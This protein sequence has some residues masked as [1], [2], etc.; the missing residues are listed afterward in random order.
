MTRVFRAVFGRLPALVLVTA[1]TL[2]PV[3]AA[4]QP[5]GEAA[6]APVER[7]TTARGQE[8]GPSL[9]PDG[10][11]LAYGA[12]TSPDNFD[13]YVVTDGG[14]P[15]NLTADYPA[16][17]G[18]PAFSP[19]GRSIA[20]GSAREGGG[21]FVMSA[22][23]GPARL[24]VDEGFDPTWSADGREILYSPLTRGATPYASSA[25][26]GGIWAVDVES[27]EKRQ[28]VAAHAFAPMMS[29]DG[30]WVAYWALG[31]G[32]VITGSA[33]RD[34][35]TVSAQGGDPVRVTNDEAIDWSPVWSPDGGQLYFASDRDGRMKIWRVGIDPGTGAATGEPELVSTD[36]GAPVRGQLWMA[37][38]G[39]LAWMDRS[40]RRTLYKTTLD[41]ATGEARGEP[42]RLVDP[43]VVS[44][45]NVAESPDG[46]WL[47]LRTG[48]ETQEDLWIVRSDG[49][50]LRQLTNDPWRDR[51]PVWS[52][53]GASIYFRS[54]RPL[55][56]ERPYLWYRISPD[57]SGLAPLGFGGAPTPRWS[58]DGGK[59][60]YNIPG[61]DGGEQVIMA[62]LDGSDR[63][64]VVS[65]SQG[66]SLPIWSP[67]SRRIGYS[68]SE[69]GVGRAFILDVTGSNARPEPLPERNFNPTDWSPDGSA[70]AGN[71]VFPDR[72]NRTLVYDIASRSFEEMSDV[73]PMA[74]WF[75]DGRRVLVFRDGGRT[76]QV[77]D[78]ETRGVREILS[79]QPPTTLGFILSR[80][81]RSLY[82]VVSELEADV[83][84]MRVR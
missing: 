72:P 2:L 65:S 30:Q 14:A 25:G 1:G 51:T 73:A 37:P 29:P 36:A 40:V 17:D 27:G 16:G 68:E 60:L 50:G 42:V 52:P 45:T 76:V 84:R 57:G 66:L 32:P 80:D 19:D 64:V 70:I 75:Q 49:T 56:G 79:V 34:I 78:R 11:S 10:R 61:E 7:L 15:R 38:N 23:G 39:T 5:A 83:Y 46:E 18:S 58:P 9:S 22:S 21:I 26:I 48:D 3:V 47:V 54:D 35:W 8:L 62:N 71:E 31:E 6:P 67:D 13:I 33:Q 4:C 41:P 74:E 82:H 59:V 69:D 77:V 24:V 53:D 28:I 44:P 43:G 81:N 55:D 20:F 63:R 12:M